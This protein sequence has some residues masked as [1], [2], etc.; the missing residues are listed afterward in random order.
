MLRD[1]LRFEVTQQHLL[2]LRRAVVGWQNCETGAPEIDPKRPYGNSDVATDVADIIG[3]NV[4]NYEDN[5]VIYDRW[6]ETRGA[7]LLALHRETEYALQCVLAAGEFAA[8]VY[9][10]PDRL[11]RRWRRIR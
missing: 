4:P 8:G 10:R 7:Q 3:E 1:A 9:E 11:S 2:L 5:E 6:L